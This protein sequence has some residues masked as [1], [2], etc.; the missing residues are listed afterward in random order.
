[1]LDDFLTWA[2]SLRQD[3]ALT[4]ATLEVALNAPCDNRSARLDIETSARLG[5]ITLWQSRE[6]FAEVLDIAS[7][8]TV[9]QQY[10]VVEHPHDFHATF[11]GFLSGCG[12]NHA[13]DTQWRSA[14][15]TFRE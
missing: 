9:F 14:K 10:G 1:M 7:E 3:S 2:Q 6:F 13:V 15:R 11:S 4:N 5:R 12:T 8:E